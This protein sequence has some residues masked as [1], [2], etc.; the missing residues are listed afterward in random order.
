VGVGV[1]GSVGSVVGVGV[2]GVGVVGVGVV[3]VGVVGVGVVGVGVVGLEDQEFT[4]ILVLH[5]TPQALHDMV[6][7]HTW[8]D[9]NVHP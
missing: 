3:G 2:V 9:V 6:N 1:V 8:V 7:V 4:V 5:N